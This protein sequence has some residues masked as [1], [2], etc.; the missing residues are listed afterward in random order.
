MISIVFNLLN[1]Y[2]SSRYTWTDG[3]SKFKKKEDNCVKAGL[4]P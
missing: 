3:Y 1:E 2:E 4:H